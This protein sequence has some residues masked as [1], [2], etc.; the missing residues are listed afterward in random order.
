MGY[1]SLQNIPAVSEDRFARCPGVRGFFRAG[2]KTTI[3][4]EFLKDTGQ[5]GGRIG[6]TD[7]GDIVFTNSANTV[8]Y[9]HEIESYNG[10]TGEL[11]AW[12][13]IPSLSGS[14]DTTVRMWYGNA[15]A[16]NQ[17]NPTGVWE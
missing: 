3:A 2:R 6:Q 10:T 14:A 7:G 13:K 8:K 9:D 15:T 1:H 11:R 4:K 17:W 5:A 12:I 16:D